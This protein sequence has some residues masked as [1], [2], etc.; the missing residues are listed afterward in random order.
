[1]NFTN[2]SAAFISTPLFLYVIYFYSLFYN[3]LLK[4][5]YFKP[6][7]YFLSVSLNL[8]FFHNKCVSKIFSCRKVEISEPFEEKFDKNDVIDK[9]FRDAFYK[10]MHLLVKSTDFDKI[11]ILN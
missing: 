11:I 10:L 1:M 5:Y 9:G 6:Y 2:L 3:N 7:I 4:K 8:F